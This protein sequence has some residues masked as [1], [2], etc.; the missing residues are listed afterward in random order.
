MRMSLQALAINSRSSENHMVSAQ[1]VTC[2][3]SVCEL[4]RS[5]QHS[6]SW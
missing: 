3:A 5:M 4:N 6:L 2:P 1:E